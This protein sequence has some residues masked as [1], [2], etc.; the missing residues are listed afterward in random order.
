MT[1][2]QKR[3]IVQF[4][5]EGLGYMRIGQLVGLTTSTVRYFCKN[6]EDG[7]INEYEYC[8]QCG[9]KL[10]QRKGI[11]KRLFCCEECRHKWW[12][13]HQERIDRKTF[14]T[15]VCEC[16]GKEFS[17]YGKRERKYCSREC[18]IKARYGKDEQA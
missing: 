17:S 10:V 18:Y 7:M 11:K 8:K 9:E 16:C 2:L 5:R 6:N 4:R 1:E 13:S 15:F 14:S 12:N 3:K